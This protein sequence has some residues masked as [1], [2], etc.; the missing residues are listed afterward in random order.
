M[1]AQ[2][3]LSQQLFHARNNADFFGYEDYPAALTAHQIVSRY[4]LGDLHEDEGHYGESEHNFLRRRFESPTGQRLA[5]SIGSKGYD[6][7]KP[8]EIYED[9]MVNDGHHRLAVM[10]FNHPNT[11]IP[12][13]HTDE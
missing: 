8:I 11:P 7:K 12:L 3:N 2:D 10:Y 1:S 9:R 5:K 4:D 6:P 13:T